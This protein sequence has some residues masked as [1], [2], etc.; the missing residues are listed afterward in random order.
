MIDL[1]L[2]KLG[3]VNPN[4]LIALL[5]APLVYITI[6]GK[7]DKPAK[8]ITMIVNGFAN[9]LRRTPKA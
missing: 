8:R 7:S 4:I 1:L 6:L 9:L 2:E 5:F 3:E